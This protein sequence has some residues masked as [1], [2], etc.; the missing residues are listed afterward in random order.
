MKLTPFEE[1][2]KLQRERMQ[3]EELEGGFPKSCLNEFAGSV[4]SDMFAD[5]SWTE[6][7]ERETGK[8][9]FVGG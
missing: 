2:M 8:S 1:H 7:Y 6:Q 9:A 5:L 4:L 3:L